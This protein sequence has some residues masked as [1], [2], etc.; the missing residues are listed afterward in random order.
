MS[1]CTEIRDL[2]GAVLDRE[3]D[4]AETE[5]VQTH[6]AECAECAELFE[7]MAMVT[8]A[9]R[10]MAKVEPPPHIS[11]EIAAS[12]CRR[13]L[14]LL[15]QAVDREIS[16]HNLD[17]L[18]S[19]LDRCPT[20]RQT[21]H[22]LTLIHQVGD[23]MEPPNHLASACI[24]VRNAVTSITVLPRRTATAAAYVLALL[25]TIAVGNPIIIAQEVQS[26]AVE[27]VSQ[28]ASGVS[29]VA[30]DGRGEIRVALWRTM[31]WG[32]S[33]IDTVRGWVDAL[34]GSDEP[35]GD[36]TPEPEKDQQGDE[37]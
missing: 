37:T 23:S 34:R 12:P 29:E 28:A 22:D 36:S 27:R 31:R 25:A 21:W 10:I 6:L 35:I 5:R 32:Q 2:F 8:N 24:Q 16:Q 9:G 30:A 11:A 17:R 7:A 20:C 4:E 18:L 15:Y 19:H 33:K 3:A 13:W 14:G 1:T 26:V